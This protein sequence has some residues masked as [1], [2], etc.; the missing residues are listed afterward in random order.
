ML[1]QWVFNIGIDLKVFLSFK[2]RLMGPVQSFIDAN[3]GQIVY[4]FEMR[5]KLEIQFLLQLTLCVSIQ[6]LL[7]LI[8]KTTA[9]GSEI[10]GQPRL[11][12]FPKPRIIQAGPEFNFKVFESTYGSVRDQPKSLTRDPLYRSGPISI[13]KLG[14][15]H[16][17][18]FYYFYFH[19][20]N[21]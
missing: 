7:R 13:S 18:T 8:K 10:Q 15:R 5:V 20:T 3:E 21:F 16:V 19:Y 6:I 17:L 2:Q 9:Q 14:V 1:Q 12:L 11:S 4:S